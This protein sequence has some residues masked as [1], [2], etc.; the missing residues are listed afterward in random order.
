[1]NESA[2]PGRRS[3]QTLADHAYDTLADAIVRG[4]LPLGARIS[5]DSLSKRFGISRGPLREALRRLE[6]RKL[7]VVKPNAGA[8][9]VSL[10]IRDIAEIYQIREALEALACQ[11]ATERM[12]DAEVAELER[13]LD[14]HDDEPAHGRASS[15]AAEVPDFH[16]AVAMGSK[17]RWLIDLVCGQLFDLIGDR[18]LEMQ[19]DEGLRVYVFPI[20][21]LARVLAELSPTG[22]PSTSE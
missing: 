22:S 2:F 12:T 14:R 1:M 7:V 11:L 3:A 13:L 8:S 15:R 17:S 4:E 6:G 18:L 20:R 10:S 9:V 16:T 19:I 21:P 5:E